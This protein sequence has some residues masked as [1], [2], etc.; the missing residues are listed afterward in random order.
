MHVHVHTHVYT[1]VKKCEYMLMRMAMQTL[2]CPLNSICVC[3]EV[4]YTL[5]SICRWKY[6]YKYLS[7]YL[8]EYVYKK[9]CGY[10]PNS[11]FHVCATCLS[12]IAC[13]YICTIH[14]SM[15]MYIHMSIRMSNHISTRMQRHIFIWTYA[16]MSIDGP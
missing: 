4:L 15:R 10:L 2:M 1:H 7:E 6:R 11:P 8:Y 16:Q 12:Q 14:V 3:T 9:F 5:Q 13:L